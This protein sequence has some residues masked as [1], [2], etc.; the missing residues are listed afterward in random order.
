MADIFQTIF[1]DEFFAN[2]WI[3]IFIKISPKF[4]PKGLIDNNLA[5]A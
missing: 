2:E 3:H 5:L 1:S 4:V